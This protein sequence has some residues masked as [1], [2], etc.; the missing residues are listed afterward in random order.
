MFPS[1][2][3]THNYK[4][5]V[6]AL[7]IIAAIFVSAGTTRQQMVAF[8]GLV[9]M[10]VET[11]LQVCISTAEGERRFP[12]LRGSVATALLSNTTNLRRI[13]C[14]ID[15]LLL[16][17]VLP[18][19][20]RQAVSAYG[21]WEVETV[22]GAVVRNTTT[23]VALGGPTGPNVPPTSKERWC[24]TFRLCGPHVLRNLPKT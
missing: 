10:S 3:L 9:L 5:P 12:Y 1:G 17:Y 8:Q 4:R 24:P 13:Y 16:L 23:V 15:L 14:Q 18:T 22:I 2:R 6:R 21:A 7:F 19:Q 20:C 11:L